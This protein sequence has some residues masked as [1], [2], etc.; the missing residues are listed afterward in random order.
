M[1]LLLEIVPMPIA[2]P[3]RIIF[4]CAGQHVQSVARYLAHS[5]P[6][7]LL[8]AGQGIYDQSLLGNLHRDLRT[9]V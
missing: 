7:V 9:K 2:A 8:F 3:P 1:H 4:C 5:S 6:W